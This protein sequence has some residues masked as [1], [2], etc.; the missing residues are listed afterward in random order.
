MECPFWLRVQA[1]AQK[2]LGVGKDVPLL[3]TKEMFLWPSA[4]GPVPDLL[5]KAAMVIGYHGIYRWVSRWFCKTHHQATENA[6]FWFEMIERVTSC[7]A[8]VDSSKSP[9]RLKA[10]Y[11]PSPENFRLL[12]TLRDGRAVAAS[13]MRREGADMHTAAGYWLN[14]NRR[15]LWSLRGIPQDKRLVVRYE[16]LC[17]EPKATMERICA[18]IG[19]PFEEDMLRLRK[20]ESHNIGGNPMRFRTEETTIKLDE[21][22]RDQLMPEDLDVFER[23]AGKLNRKLGYTD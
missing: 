9:R 1:E 4:I 15:V 18:F 7:S 16:A 12:F 19:I 13:G 20:Q 17:R 21:Q 2:E 14:S 6:L 10:L 11:L 5:Q 23:V 3:K 8:I 22:W